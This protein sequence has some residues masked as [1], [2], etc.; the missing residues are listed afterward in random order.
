MSSKRI[1]TSTR[2]A[3]KPKRDEIGAG[4]DT[5]GRILRAAREVLA[6]AGYSRF[7]MRAV[8]RGA[9]VAVGNLVYYYPSKRS[10]IHAVILSLLEYYRRKSSE[11]L[12][13]SGRGPSDGLAKLIRY[14]MSDS[15]ASE[16]SRLFRELWAMALHDAEIAEAM[17]GF[18]SE[19][20]LTAVKLVQSAHP[21]L[22]VRRAH[23]IVQ[24]L[25]TISEGANVI[26]AT[27]PTS[28]AS[29]KRVAK[30]AGEL[31]VRVAT[32]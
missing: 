13:M 31:L 12:R 30:L 26:F 7:T 9:G 6:T 1:R 22:T 29:R 21:G 23:D 3:R 25:G 20:H 27:A 2:G 15:V 24:L 16:T 4:D 14:Y 32:D 8:A 17:D 28:A 19:L 10:L 18:Y 5:R 11:Y